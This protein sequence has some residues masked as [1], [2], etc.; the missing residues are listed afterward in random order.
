MAITGIGTDVLA[1]YYSARANLRAGGVNAAQ[2]GN[3]APPGKNTPYPPWDPRSTPVPNETLAKNVLAGKKF[4]DLNAALLKDRTLDKDYNKMFALNTALQSLQALAEAADKKNVSAT[5]LNRM[6]KRFGE[7]LE[8]V[9]GFLRK[10]KL[11]KVK[12]IKGQSVTSATTKVGVKRDA[13]YYSTGVLHTG[14]GEDEVARFTGRVQFKLTATKS[15][16]TVI[17]KEIDLAGMG[18]TTRTMGAVADYINGELDS[19]GI[20]SRLTRVDLTPPPAD[21][22]KISTAPKQ[23]G[24]KITGSVTETLTFS[25]LAANAGDDNNVF[26]AGTEVN[27][28][29]ATNTIGRVGGYNEASGT[30]AN[31]VNWTK[32]VKTEAG[33]LNI[34]ASATAA[35]GSY[36]VIADVTGVINNQ[37]IKGTSDVAL[38]KYD[39]AGNTIFTRT[40]GA[41]ATGKGFAISA[42]ADG[43]VAIAG[44]VVGRLTA[45]DVGY[46]TDSYVAK[47]NAD[48]EE[49]WARRRGSVLDDE[50]TAVAVGDD[51]SVIIGGRTKASIS[52]ENMQ[53]GYDNYIRK[54]DADGALVFTDQFGS[55]SDDKITALTLVQATAGS[56]GGG[57]TVTTDPRDAKLE[58]DAA[59]DFTLAAEYATVETFVNGTYVPPGGGVVGANNGWTTRDVQK[60]NGNYYVLA[61]NG[62]SEKLMKIAGDFTSS[63]ETYVGSILGGPYESHI[64]VNSG[65]IGLAGTFADTPED[66]GNAN[67]LKL[68]TYSTADLSALKSK[69]TSLGAHNMT[70]TAVN[71]DINTGNIYFNARLD[72]DQNGTAESNVFAV[73]DTTK[74]VYNKAEYTLDDTGGEDRV[75]KIVLDDTLTGASQRYHAIGRRGAG[76]VDHIIDTSSGIITQQGTVNFAP[77]GLTAKIFDASVVNGSVYVSGSTTDTSIDPQWDRE[78]NGTINTD[79]VTQITHEASGSPQHFNMWFDAVEMDTASVAY[80]DPN[81]GTLGTEPT[82]GSGGGGGATTGDQ[83]LYVG[84][85]EGTNSVVRVFTIADGATS[86]TAGTVFNLGD[87]GGGGVTAIKGADD[88]IYIGGTTTN[89][90]L[91]FQNNGVNITTHASNAHGGGQDGFVARID[92]GSNTAAVAFVGTSADDI[93][94]SMTLTG[95]TATSGGGGTTSDPRDA[96]L[97]TDAASDFALAT[98]YDTVRMAV[99]AGGAG[100]VNIYDIKKSGSEYFALSRDSATNAV[101][102]RRFNSAFTQTHSAVVGTITNTNQNEAHI[103]VDG[104]KVGLVG[105][106]AT[107]ADHPAADVIKF[108]TYDVSNLSEIENTETALGGRKMLVTATTY[109]NANGRLYAAARLDSDSNGSI[110]SGRLIVGSAASG[111]AAQ[112]AFAIDDSFTEDRVKVIAL[113]D[114]ATGASQRYHLIGSQNDS[115]INRIIDTDSNSNAMSLTGTFNFSP[116]GLESIFDASVVN[117]SV[118]ISGTTADHSIDPQ[119]DAGDDGAGPGDT[120]LV[121][122][123]THASAGAG[124]EHFNLWIDAVD[125]DK[126]AVAYSNINTGVLGTPTGSGGSGG[127]VDARDNDLEPYGDTQLNIAAKTKI[128]QNALSGVANVFGIMDTVNDGTNFYSLA[129]YGAPN[130]SGAQTMRIFKT[131]ATGAVLDTVDYGEIVNGSQEAH[132]AVNSGVLAIAGTFRTANGVSNA[133]AV[134]GV[135]T[136]DTAT[137]T[138]QDSFEDTYGRPSKGTAVTLDSSGNLYMVAHSD[139]NLNGTYDTQHF[140]KFDTSNLPV[141]GVGSWTSGLLTNI[142]TDEGTTGVDLIKKIVLDDVNTG[143]SQQYYLVGTQ[144]DNGIVRTL[145]TNTGTVSVSGSMNFGNNNPTGVYDAYVDSGNLYIFGATEDQSLDPQWDLHD[146]GSIQTDLDTHI[147]NAY[148]TPGMN[149]F[150][151]WIDTQGNDEAGV[152]YFDPTGVIGTPVDN[153]GGSS[154]GSGT[155]DASAI[156]IGGSTGGALAGNDKQGTQDGF[157]GKLTFDGTDLNIEYTKQFGR[158]G[159]KL[160]GVQVGVSDGSSD[161]AKLGLP[162]GTID[163]S[164]SKLITAA[165]SAR[166]GDHFYVKVNGRPAVKIAVATDDTM[167]T[168]ASKVSRVLNV[169]G[170][171]EA[172]LGSNG[173]ALNIKASKGDRIELIAGAK[174]QDLLKALS[175]TEGVVV[176]EIK[177]KNGNVIN[178]PSQPPIYALRL[179]SDM[180]IDTKE[181]RAK[182]IQALSASI[183]AVK[184]AYRESRQTPEERAQAAKDAEKLAALKKAPSGYMQG[185]I[186]N[187]QQALARL[188]G[189]NPGGGVT[190]LF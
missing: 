128:V 7:G 160:T 47:F 31:N 79:L 6:T 174:G 149:Y 148:T 3:N 170:K 155:T 61:T 48:G 40:L 11:E 81:T 180:R 9:D 157:F 28:T 161:L 187:Y 42:G 104:N 108:T 98:A 16:G 45:N 87:L 99:L 142:T 86:P 120:D 20:I 33:A 19:A 17:N 162:S 8:E 101:T 169:D 173:T 133:N 152:A 71:Y 27:V 132:L 93:V 178:Q 95:V 14:S 51:G 114:V 125:N 115:G 153:G 163:Y 65:E 144:G 82:G 189:G 109:D 89:A 2:S 38:I 18:S 102:L 103:D 96:K 73:A 63:S 97:I 23:W 181:E 135:A 80:S 111:A 50:A 46:L 140:L 136:F 118:Y 77:S 100:A 129:L 88:A 137:L 4:V 172:R 145:Q 69:I 190:S 36:Y 164:D 10:E 12:F 62:D 49:Q 182:T 59:S 68:A 67:V 150:T 21:P 75:D 74:G 34:R 91:Q 58:T 5:D 154:G 25:P 134:I 29:K 116:S 186:S 126:A 84:G 168:L 1:G 24:F 184:R 15:D 188:Q 171:A 117:G 39:S 66:P 37:P 159:T 78:D 147:T 143:S 72:S 92:T 166:T 55:S 123:I 56:T 70:V 156:Y 53:G 41:A 179:P 139:T 158:T 106:F 138:L 122:N 85:F 121:T 146:D 167:R 43:S 177:D 83:T 64:Y 176:N 44:S 175:L 35:D 119:W 57:G 94:S 26:V 76:G 107:T 141:S 185:Q 165:S 54:Y 183:S 130:G 90:S 110:D 127:T 13:P 30:V 60:Y 52:G 22:K 151:M 112:T 131:D 124:K 105:T 32:D 113:D